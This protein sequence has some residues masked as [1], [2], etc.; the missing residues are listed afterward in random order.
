MDIV[1]FYK[2]DQEYPIFYIVIYYE[3][4]TS[5]KERCSIAP[6]QGKTYLHLF[7]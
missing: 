7:I 4:M 3:F 2:K 6:I 1:I 5:K